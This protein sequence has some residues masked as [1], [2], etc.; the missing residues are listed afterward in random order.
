MSGRTPSVLARDPEALRALAHTVRWKLIDV[1][2]EEDAV[3][4]TRCA[5]IL[6][7]STATCSY[8]LGILAK[9]GYI[10][11]V[12]SRP[13]EWREKPW[14]L[15]TKNLNL[16]PASPDAKDA[17]A[18]RD[19]AAALVEFELTWLKESLRR[20]ADEPTSWL[21]TTKILG[22]TAWMTA[23]Q[24][25]QAAAEVQEVLDK[26][27]PPGQVA[28]ERQEGTRRVRMFAAIAP[29]LPSAQLDER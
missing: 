26:Y 7:L 24:S 15:V 21:H 25:R 10:T 20:R 4:A 17:A 14:R 5:S 13:G 16:P 28:A 23:E 3:T 11:R 19:A 27:S 22:V 2:M 9:Y 1:L 29:G 8:H 6:G 12:A 18:S